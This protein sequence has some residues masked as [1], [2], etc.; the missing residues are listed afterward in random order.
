VRVLFCVNSFPAPSQ[1][2]VDSQIT[3]LLDRGF[4][5]RIVSLQPAKQGPRHE[6]TLSYDLIARTSYVPKKRRRALLDLKKTVLPLLLRRPP[7]ERYGRALR[8]LLDKSP[9]A[10]FRLLRRATAFLEQWPFDAIVCHFGPVGAQVQELRDAGVTEAPLITFFHGYDVSRTVD[11]HGASLYRSLFD[12][13]ELLLPISQFWRNKLI[14]LGA[15]EDRTEVHHMGVNTHEIRFRPRA[16]VRGEPVTLISIARLTEKKGI[17]YAL[18]ALA[19]LPPDTPAYHYHVVGDGELRARLERL[20]TE[21]G[22][23]ARVTFHGWKSQ[24]EVAGLL[25]TAHVLLQPSVTASDG[26]QEGI[27]VALMEAMAAGM[28]VVSTLHTGIPELVEDGICGYLVPE[29]D[30]AALGARIADLLRTPELWA[31]L[32]QAGR[33]R[34]EAEFDVDVLNDRLAQRI[35]RV[36]RG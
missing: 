19:L 7:P 29:R 33:A 16:L 22:L 35:E 1:T 10:S 15:P 6:H 26:D 2:F 21:L 23:D 27:P 20:R 18:R 9:E 36:A 5:V 32:G 24:A 12:S 30:V 31:Q 25:D 13:G 28:P 4:D 34:V 3:G 17:E 14:G 11:E 8:S